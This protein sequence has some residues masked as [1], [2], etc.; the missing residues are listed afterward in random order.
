MRQAEQAALRQCVSSQNKTYFNSSICP[1]LLEERKYVVNLIKINS[2]SRKYDNGMVWS[3]TPHVTVPQ[4]MRDGGINPNQICLKSIF[5]RYA[6]WVK[7]Y[8][9]SGS[10]NLQQIQPVK[11]PPP[12][13]CTHWICG[14]PKTPPLHPPP[15]LN[16]WCSGSR[17][18]RNYFQRCWGGSV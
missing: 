11:S 7:K 13:K 1:I 10:K 15:L 3:R 9:K 8:T 14:G 2:S 17:D 18:T 6:W 16:S 5:K 4:C 12:E